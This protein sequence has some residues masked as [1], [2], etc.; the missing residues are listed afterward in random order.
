M[1]KP[2]N[3]WLINYT[4]YCI[5][6]L[7]S[8]HCIFIFT[9]IGFIFTIKFLIE[10]IL[11][12][13]QGWSNILKYQYIC[14]SITGR[15]K[16]QIKL[17]TPPTIDKCSNSLDIPISLFWSSL[18][19]QKPRPNSSDGLYMAHT[20]KTILLPRDSLATKL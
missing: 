15:V 3:V 7:M 4:Q 11:P 6:E 1:I 20:Y 8:M 2:R 19:F 12:I 9:D 10:C 13:M 5:K 17:S 14:H 18:Q 16:L